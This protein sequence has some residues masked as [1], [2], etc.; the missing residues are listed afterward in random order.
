[1]LKILLGEDYLLYMPIKRTEC[2]IEQKTG[3][4]AGGQQKIRGAWPTQLPPSTTAALREMGPH[5]GLAYG[6]RIS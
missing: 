4:Q 2:E 5:K 1:L 3:G 6:P